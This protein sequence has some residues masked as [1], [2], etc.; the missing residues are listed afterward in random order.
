VAAEGDAKLRVLEMRWVLLAFLTLLAAFAG[1]AVALRTKPAGRAELA[2]TSCILWNA[3]I[4]CPIYALGLTNHLR[5]TPLAIL[6]GIFFGCVLAGAG[7][8]GSIRRSV[9]E[10]GSGVV[11][12][13][14][15][16]F[17]GIAMVTRARSVVAI[18]LLLIAFLIVYT[19][20]A[21]YFTPS[22]RQWDALWYHETIIGFTIQN[23]GFSPVDL[24]PDL[25]KV[26]GYP[27]F[28]EMFQM[29]F[30]IFTDRR[31]IDLANS[32]I[33]PGLM[34]ATFVIARR[35]TKD[36][37]ACMGWAA[38]VM[39][40][41]TVSYL[42]DSIYIDIQ[43]AFFVVAATHYATRPTF[44]LADAGLAAVC[45]TLAVGSK[46]LALPPIAI[47]AL[48][49]LLRLL[50]HH[51]V[52]LRS[53]ATAAGGSALILGMAASAYWR[54]WIHYKNPFW[55]DLA[56]DNAKYKIHLPNIAFQPNALDLNMPLRDLLTT[57]TSVP[58]SVGGLG[59]KGQIYDYGF[60]VACFVFPLGALALVGA[61]LLCVRDLFGR[62][63]RVPQWLCPDA[64]NVMLVA[65]PM[66]VSVY[67]SPALWGAR[68]HIANVAVLTTLIAFWSG[69]ARWRMFGEGVVAAA[70]VMS[71]VVFYWVKP[72]WLWTPSELAKLIA[73][74]YPAREVTPTALVAPTLD[75]H[76]GSAMTR[77]A[78]L[79]RAKLKSG[80]VVA[81]NDGVQFPAL[82][83]NDTYSNKLVYL[84]GEK[85]A[86][87]AAAI[88]AD[89]AYC[90]SGDPECAA[91]IAAGWK[92]AGELNVEHW[93]RIYWNPSRKGD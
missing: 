71:I 82:L 19:G 73:V 13:V 86:A 32:L 34:Y 69:R 36:I 56:Y 75:L 9:R 85:F 25:Q 45:I 1:V 61:L 84:H 37:V 40:M 51:G 10:V 39:L 5:A 29:W 62:A 57:I 6:S 43:V 64:T 42:L 92:D 11:R 7:W 74:P 79:E 33:A 87:Q 17:D 60:A 28:C 4:G 41:P 91:L 46:V 31:L 15:L 72:R 8:H 63:L 3:L 65:F 30:A 48:I 89:M 81:F 24:P 12:I 77:E 44:R 78:G 90:R 20:V 27:R 18:A 68:Y 38:V 49:T 26:N 58:Y 76:S 66:M 54:N 67:T 50:R 21:S 88:G 83:W 2:L 70:C 14:T 16:P 80:D 22:W 55:P 47:I 93:G 35:Y 53:L 59:P 23:H 52:R